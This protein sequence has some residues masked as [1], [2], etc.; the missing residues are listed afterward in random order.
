MPEH[1]QR[2]SSPRALVEDFAHTAAAKR[3]TTMLLIFF[4]FLA[5]GLLLALPAINAPFFWDDLHLVRTHTA[6]ELT[7]AWSDTY[8]ADHFENPGFRPL[9]MYFEHV[10]ALLFGENV[11]AH[12]VFLLVLFALFLTLVGL[13]A[14]RLFAVSGWQILLGGLVGLLHIHS[15]SHYFWPTDGIFLASGILII[16]ALLAFLNALSSER[17]IWLFVSFCCTA[18]ALLTREDSVTIYPLLLWFGLAFVLKKKTQ[19]NALGLPK[20][21][22]WLFA[23][24]LLAILGVYWYWRGVAVPNAVPLKVNPAALLWGAAQTVQDVGDH[25]LLAVAWPKYDLIISLWRAWLGVLV[26]IGLF[27]LERRAQLIVLF[28]AGAIL[29]A[30]A[31]VLVVARTNLLLLPVAFWGLLVAHVLAQYWRQSSA[32]GPRVFVSGM[33]LFALAAP[34]YGSLLFEQEMGPNNLTWMC[35]NAMLLYGVSGPVTIPPAR[36]ASVQQELTAYGMSDLSD[37]EARWPS[38]ERKALADGRYGVNAQG[39]P[40]IPRFEF[41]PQFQI[42]PRCEPPK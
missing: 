17:P 33:M 12:R 15:V 2:L 6:D 32:I 8:D 3:S 25:Q 9:T 22:V 11:A 41:L 34:A 26:V 36:R 20:F 19:G 37:F 13:L 29:I 4:C 18:L 39:L 23:A 38:M 21:S 1:L 27:F 30:A 24:A 28:W 42:H 31:P 5:V 10:R 40:F 16:G 35:R 14:R 7:R